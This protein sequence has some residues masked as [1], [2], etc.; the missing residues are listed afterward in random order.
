MG[1]KA[2]WVLLRI[3]GALRYVMWPTDLWNNRSVGVDCSVYIHSAKAYSIDDTARLNPVFRNLVRDVT[4]RINSVKMSGGHPV[5][6][7]DGGCLPGKVKEE[8]K[9]HGGGDAVR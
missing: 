3:A 2:F 4:R 8:E 6:V 9:R 7:L 5:V 1:V